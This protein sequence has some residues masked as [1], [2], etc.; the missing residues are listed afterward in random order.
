MALT[1]KAPFSGWVSPIS[2]LP[3][4]VFG[5]KMLGDGVAI[6]PLDQVI[7]APCNGTIS[8]LS[9]AKHAVAIIAAN[10]AEL[11]IHVGL[12]T[13]A[14]QGQGFEVLVS[15]GQ[16]VA[17][18]E[19]ILR[20]DLDFLARNAPNLITPLVLTNSDQFLIQERR[21]NCLID[22]GAPLMTIVARGLA[23]AETEDVAA[24]AG[25]AEREINANFEHGLHARPAA[26]IVACARQ[27]RCHITVHAQERSANARSLV[28]IMGLGVQ[29]GERIRL[30]A[31][32]AD[33]VAALDALER[34][35]GGE[36]PSA[37]DPM[38]QPH[39]PGQLPQDGILKGVRMAGGMVVGCAWHVKSRVADFP[40]FGS[41]VTT[42]RESLALATR[43][44]AEQLGRTMA[45]ASVLQREILD[46]HLEILNDPEIGSH[47]QQLI[48]QGKS[49]AFAWHQ[50]ISHYRGILANCGDQHIAARVDDLAD[51]EQLVVEILCGS[52]RA[53]DL[54][55]PGSILVARDLLP[56]QLLDAARQAI[57]GVCLANGGAT[58]HVAILAGEI[59][60]PA[61]A[62]VGD[63]VLTIPAGTT[64]ILDADQGM[65][66]VEPAS[67][68]IERV[69]AQLKQRHLDELGAL[70]SAHLPCAL[71]SGERLEVL[72]N[73]GQSDTVSAAIARGAEGCGLLRS[74]F[75]F[76]NRQSPPEYAEQR[77]IYQ[78]IVDDF[79]GLPVTIRTL[80]IGGDKR[81]PFLDQGHIEN[82]ALGPRGIRLNL[83]H[84]DILEHQI[85]AISQVTPRGSCHLLLPMIS[86]VEEV[87]DIRNLLA[88]IDGETATDTPIQLGAMIETPAAALI[89]EHLATY[90]DFLAIGSNDLTQ[91]VL[92]M[93]RNDTRLTAL[94]DSLHPAILTLIAR[95]GEA[96]RKAGIPVS[97]C[98]AMAADPFA[99]PILI[100]CGVSKLSVSQ[101]ALPLVKQRV[102]YLTLSSC[103]ALAREAIALPTSAAVRQAAQRFF[104]AHPR[105]DATG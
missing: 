90:L 7:R 68:E 31:R 26:R 18:G 14:L 92:A 27:F 38:S 8:K 50:A 64:L 45:Q 89:A 9:S 35:I 20:I 105:E 25:T 34:L 76:E 2:D 57:A 59:G 77:Q 70:R 36:A 101:A 6:D 12:E 16:A 81:V 94:L 49:A 67:D 88:R 62:A 30:Q 28:A 13:V 17:E 83:T 47:T 71:A 85:R 11:M 75:L 41:G 21:E 79:S 48:D 23:A 99:M 56:S 24:T 46:A 91:Y 74:E 82:P 55:P 93:D 97:V 51:V 73:L 69:S 72:V 39:S 58:S 37:I 43:G 61:I 104:D 33:G 80:D 15:E 10:G 98:G 1:V 40:E 84:P 100:G 103:R 66:Q 3:D 95:V 5:C 60:I 32:G 44:V 4:P 87:L 53:K 65:L 42:E 63:R 78:Q 29:H 102:R 52:E 54:I 22:S 19:A 86:S 96:G